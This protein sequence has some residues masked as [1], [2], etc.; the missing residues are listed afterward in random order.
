MRIRAYVLHLE[1]AT[2]RRANADRLLETCGLE[3]EIW[4]AVDGTAM[5]QDERSAV[6]CP[7][8][9]QPEYPFPLNAGEIGCFLSHRQ[10]WADILNK[11]L[12][13]ALI[14][15]DD[16][17]IIESEFSSAVQLASIHIESLGFIK[18]KSHPPKAKY[19]VLDHLS[20]AN[21][22]KSR[23][24]GLGA[25][26][27]MVSSKAAKQLLERSVVIDRP[28]DT[29]VQSYWYTGLQPCVIYPS[30][31]YHC[32]HKVGGTTIQHSPENLI[33]KIR[34]EIKRTIYRRKVRI[35]SNRE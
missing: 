13:A 22:V 27:Q 15:E 31:V 2:A 28:V 30:G 5:S 17:K 10:I 6:I 8:L 14:L 23:E 16:I 12:D 19:Q 20:T 9:F 18:F 35:L 33:Q 3:G 1:R 32:D 34:R 25:T 29:F 7:R 11:E 24:P 21:L 26:A 4:P